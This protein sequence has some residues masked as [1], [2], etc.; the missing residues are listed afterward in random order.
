MFIFTAIKWLLGF[1]SGPVLDKI[2]GHIQATQASHVEELKVQAGVDVERIRADIAVQ[3]YA[4]G[5]VQSGMQH[6]MFWVAWSMA[7]VPLAAW[8]AWGVL[9]SM[10]G[11][12]LPDTLP[13]RGQLLDFANIV[14]GNIFYAGGAVASANVIARAIAQRAA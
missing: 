1:A 5:V 4:A 8:F 12:S 3:G 10:L 13:M 6:K 7:A 9:D 14:W 11:D 2:L